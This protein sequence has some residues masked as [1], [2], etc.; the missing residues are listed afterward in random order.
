MG[1]AR[2]E[3]AAF[4]FVGE[5][6]IHLSNRPEEEAVRL[7]LTTDGAATRVQAVLFI[8][9]DRLRRSGRAET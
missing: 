5:C 9:P 6:S 4:R 7:E 3:L 8:Q 1:P 2:L